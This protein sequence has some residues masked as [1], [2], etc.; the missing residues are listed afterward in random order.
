[1]L[2]TILI[3]FAAALGALLAYAATRPDSFTIE[4]SAR[5]KAAPERVFALINDLKAFNGWNPYEKK[6]PALKGTYAGP[7]A[8]VGA[9]YGWESREVGV[10]SLEIV[11]TAAPAKV[12][13]KLDFVRPF[14]AHNRAEFTIRPAPDGSSEV[15]WAMHGPQ[16][17]VSKLMGVI[18]NMDKMVGK[19]FEEGL[20]NLKAQA[21]TAPA[22]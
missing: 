19:D 12:A 4:R 18:F 2:K 3:A 22:A 1:M 7:Q 8:G 10:G 5:V 11:E 21:E 15:T 6:D 16:T 17:Y 14:E 9:R 20:A 13:M